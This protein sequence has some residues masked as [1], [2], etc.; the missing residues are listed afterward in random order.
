MAPVNR[1]VAFKY[2]S[3]A[4]DD[5]SE[6]RLTT[7]SRW[8]DVAFITQFKSDKAETNSWLVP[9][10]VLSRWLYRISWTMCSFMIL[11][12]ALSDF[13]A[14]FILV[15]YLMSDPDARAAHCAKCT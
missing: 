2:K 7:S 10:M 3:E 4:P 14:V 5:A 13:D 15:L 12:M 11:R 9:S 6:E 1:F 8:F